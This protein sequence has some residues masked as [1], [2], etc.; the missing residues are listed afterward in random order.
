M[1]MHRRT[2]GIFSAMVLALTLLLF[3]LGAIIQGDGLSQAALRQSSY[4][5][6]VGSTRGM[7]YDQNFQPLVGETVEAVAAVLPGEESAAL[8]G[9]LSGE[10]REA[11]TQKLAQ[12]LPFLTRL[13]GE[14]R[15]FPAGVTPMERILRYRKS[16]QLAPH[17]IGYLDGENGA[18]GIE[19]AYDSL[20]K[21]FGGSFCLRYQINA[22]GSPIGGELPQEVQ[23]GYGRP[24]GVVLTL[25]KE[26]QSIAQSAA[27]RWIDKG[28]VVV[29]DVRS[30][31]L[32]AVVSLPDF[33]P[34]NL[35]KSMTQKDSPFFNRAFHG[36]Y[37]VGSTFKLVTASTALEQGIS[38]F[39]TFD[40]TGAVEVEDVTFHCHKL[41]G[42]GVLDMQGAMEWSCNP[43]FITLGQMAG[44]ENILKKAWAIG[45]G[46]P[47]QLAPGIATASGSLPALEA[48]ESPAEV[49][50]LAFGQGELTATPVQIAQLVSTVANGGKSVHPRLVYGTTEDGLSIQNQEEG[51]AQNQVISPAAA[52]RVAQFMVDTVEY[53]S[54]QKAKPKAGG[55]GGKTASAQTGIYED[56]V[57]IVHAWFAGF[58]PAEEPQYTIVVLAEGMESGGDYAAPVFQEIADGI[59][60]YKGMDFPQPPASD[61]GE[62]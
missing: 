46:S 47:S 20:L 45:F 21:Q 14:L 52:K 62:S 48:M 24:G 27:K 4:L 1:R 53:G 61:E 42:H 49:A 38:R 10:E 37:N 19:K 17:V 58:Y 36:E 2:V 57:E 41:S 44:G 3:R 33:D 13:P 51:Y 50:N 40:C 22:A 39:R 56:G 32:L 28:A 11:F 12:R 23:E 18:A 9:K 15:S 5:L 7:I 60:D 16:G 35:S 54:G 6:E 59:A 31:D 30:G 34:N 26:I 8:A 43:Y 29:M 25:D 55:A